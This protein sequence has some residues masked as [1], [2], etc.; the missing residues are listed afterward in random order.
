MKFHTMK[1]LFCVIIAWAICLQ[2]TNLLWVFI[3]FECNRDY[4]EQQ[5]CINRYEPAVTCKGFCYLS[6]K[7]VEQKDASDMLIKTKSAEIPL[8]V[9][10]V[11][12]LNWQRPFTLLF[13][14]SYPRAK[15]NPLCQGL[16]SKIFKPP[17][18]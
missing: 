3:G 10:L 6:E 9:Q 15:G 1:G 12:E 17:I 18:V 5:L 11:K 2:A 4:I 14:I 8:F 13:K 16:F 7:T